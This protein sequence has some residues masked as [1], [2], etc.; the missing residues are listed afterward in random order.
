VSDGRRPTGLGDPLPEVDPEVAGLL[1]AEPARQ[2]GTLDT[3]A[4][5]SFAPR[6]VLEVQGRF[7]VA[8]TGPG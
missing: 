6:A 5:E 2:Q 8:A 3:V 4:S 1:D 7:P